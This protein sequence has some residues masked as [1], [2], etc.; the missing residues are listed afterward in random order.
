[1]A[2]SFELDVVVSGLSLVVPDRAGE[3]LHV[4]MMRQEHHDPHFPRLIYDRAYE[5][6][7][8]TELS[9]DLACVRLE[10]RRL[11]FGEPRGLDLDSIP[12]TVVNLGDISGVA[13]LRR[14][15]V[16]VRGGEFIARLDLR[17]GRCT[18][19]TPGAVWRVEEA[20]AGPWEGEITTCMTWT[21]PPI[22]GDRL[23]SAR[24]AGPDGGDPTPLRTLYPIGGRIRVFVFN[25][26]EWQLPPVHA[27]VRA[28]ALGEPAEHFDAYFAF[29][30]ANRVTPRIKASREPVLC[31]PEPARRSDCR[32]AVSFRDAEAPDVTPYTVT[33]LLALREMEE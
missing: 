1:M 20:P 26:P 6:P 8:S 15:Q 25:V 22:P 31:G 17:G 29:A 7:G 23:E 28:A 16:E 12:R 3:A 19:T 13:P 33:C 18:D 21:T 14:E 2:E 24:L 5:R 32:P 30:A 10:E 9:G 4:L 27:H 11:G